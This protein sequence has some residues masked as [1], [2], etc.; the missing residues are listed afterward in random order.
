MI[1]INSKV[2]IINF[3]FKLI[4]SVIFCHLLN[5]LFE[6]IDGDFFFKSNERIFDGISIQ[7]L[8]SKPPDLKSNDNKLKLK[9][10]KN[11]SFFVWVLSIFIS[12][13]SY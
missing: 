13:I 8:S 9:K 12:F 1:I 2:Y 7:K 10:K 4:L 3:N 5:T 11:L 6:M